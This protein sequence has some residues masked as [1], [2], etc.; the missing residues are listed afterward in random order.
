MSSPR[1]APPKDL[2]AYAWLSVAAAVTTIALKAGAAW[3]TGSVGLLS[4]ATESLVNLVAAVVALIVLKVSIRPADE[5]HQFGHSKAEYLSAVVEG[6][7]IFVAA[8][9]II[10]SAVERVL[11]PVM[12]ER[13]GVG[14]AVSVVA[15][16]INA[17]VA[18][19]LYRTGRA[20]RSA[21]LVADATHLATDVMTSVA[22]LFGVGL[23][24]VFQS[25]VL[26]AV[27]ALGAGLNIMW[28]GFRLLSESVAGLMDVAPSAEA[29]A[30]IN[31][32]LDGH[33]VEGRVDF[34]AV[35]VREAGNRRF[36]HV[37]VLVPGAW[38]VKE[39]H[40]FTEE[41]IDELVAADPSLRVSAHLEPIEDPRS[42]DD[43]DDV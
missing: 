31:A 18:A 36:A 9:F 24:A 3:M 37:H 35:R 29:L 43:V 38:T 20:E 17:V 10:V 26:D 33:R 28:T 8:A 21:T 40:D 32:V 39:G 19:V 2:S 12:P 13:L 11:T 42:Y 6:A 41:L 27:V 4:D 1:Y 23:V 14:L 30:A 25:P 34:H 15:S 5:D 22:V 16:V 7:L